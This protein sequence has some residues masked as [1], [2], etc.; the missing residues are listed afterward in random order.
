MKK[1]YK[2]K[3]QQR[4]YMLSKNF[5]IYYYEDNSLKQ[6]KDHIHN[7]Y[8]FY[9][10]LEGD[11][12]MV[13]EDVPYQ[14]K[15]GDTI[16]IPPNVR[17]H[18]AIHSHKVP[19][20][21]F[22]FWISKDFC[23]ELLQLSPDYVFLM[24]HAFVKKNYIFHND[25]IAFNT[26]QSKIFRLIEELNGERFGKQAQIMLCV[27][28]L[29]LHLNR[30]V[31][32]KINVQNPS[33]E[34]SLYKGLLNFIDEHLDE[35]LSLDRLAVE[36]Y[37]SKYHISHVFKNNMGI[38]LHQY[39]TKKRLYACKEAMCSSMSISEAYLMFGFGDYSSFF[40]AFKKEFGLSPREYRDMHLNDA[41]LESFPNI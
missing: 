40:R 34:E 18:V 27:Q 29:L 25:V 13:I 14:L 26:I 1:N 16:L 10:F 9:F 23:N 5:E 11:V 35:P 21:R 24:Q 17:H 7:Y 3:F 33:E 36:F 6:V 41:T 15:A 19:Y 22:V 39:I 28:D 20:R 30:I 37:V 8:E 2:T 12:S 4:Q 31:H 38:S 32:E